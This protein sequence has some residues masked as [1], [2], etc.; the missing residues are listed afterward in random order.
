MTLMM[1][2][3]IQSLGKSQVIMLIISVVTH[4]FVINCY[5]GGNKMNILGNLSVKKRYVVHIK[6]K[7]SSNNK[8]FQLRNTILFQTSPNLLCL[9]YLKFCLVLQTSNGRKAIGYFTLKQ[10]K[11]WGQSNDIFV[12]GCFVENGHCV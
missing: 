1:L 3:W 5:T 7:I 10:S 4:I 8:K 12:T 9:S 11:K 2:S 6:N